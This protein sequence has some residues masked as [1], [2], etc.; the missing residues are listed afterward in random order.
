MADELSREI[1]KLEIRLKDVMDEGKLYLKAVENCV[2]KFK[3]I[4]EFIKTHR[5]DVEALT[6]LRLEAC[7]ALTEVMKA[8]S[9][10]EHEKSHLLESYGALVFTME[11]ELTNLNKR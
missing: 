11:R 4:K 10:V 1:Q 2:A 6:K 8:Q 7:E 5:E 3:S 9:K